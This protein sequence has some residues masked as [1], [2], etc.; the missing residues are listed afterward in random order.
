MTT[1][2]VLLALALLAPLVPVAHADHGGCTPTAWT[3][4]NPTGASVVALDGGETD[5]YV[6][7]EY[8]RTTRYVRTFVETNDLPG[9][10]PYDG[11]CGHAADHRISEIC[12]T[13]QMTLE[14]G[15]CPSAQLSAP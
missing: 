13:T 12:V 11:V 14:G 7:V 8:G 6:L 9:L 2:R 5:I 10:Q 15:E 3:G 1:T 4:V